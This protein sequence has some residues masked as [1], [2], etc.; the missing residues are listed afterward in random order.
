ML[1]VS[2]RLVWVVLPISLVVV[3]FLSGVFNASAQGLQ[4]LKKQVQTLAPTKKADAPDEKT[5][6]DGLKEA[7]R[8]GTGKT[9]DH[10]SQQGV[11]MKEP[12][13]TIPLPPELKALGQ[14]LTQ[15]GM[16][17]EVDEFILS[18]NQAAE[19][20]APKAR[21]IFIEALQKMTLVDAIKIIQGK[22]DEATRYFQ[23][24]TTENLTKAFTPPIHQALESVGSTARYRKLAQ[25]YNS[26]PLVKKV[27]VDLDKYVTDKT[28][29]A[30]FLLLAEEESRIRKESAA[31]TTPL[32]QRVF[33]Y[34]A[35]PSP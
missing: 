19:Q 25:K 35:K 9:V 31:R 5:V 12:R 2:S 7:L 13:L 16:K 14:R 6:A 24:N 34:Y 15:L 26:L 3:L 4:G 1:K 21:D 20:A 10:L 28:L 32:L 33:G 18:L 23:T 22:E 8:V 27:E 17:Q 30:M 11:F 29:A